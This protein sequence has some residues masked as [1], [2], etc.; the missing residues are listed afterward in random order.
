MDPDLKQALL[1]F[2]CDVR[3][4]LIAGRQQGERHT[5]YGLALLALDDRAADLQDRLAAIEGGTG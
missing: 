2:L 3:V 5:P 4:E 1:A